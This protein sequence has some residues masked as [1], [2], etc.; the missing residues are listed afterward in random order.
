M[1]KITKTFTI[2][3]GHR[4]YK[5]TGKCGHIHGHTGSVEMV[6]QGAYVDE[7]GMLKNFDSIKATVGKWLDDNLD[8]HMLLSKDDP[9]V[10][11]LTDAGEKL[12]ILN[13]NPTAENLA[14]TIYGVAKEQG[15]PVFE[16]KFWESPTSS[17]TYSE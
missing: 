9:L 2:C 3:Y 5:D 17:A 1:Y 16:V 15:L 14:R 13:D 8:H 4:L 12:Y 11:P 7:L 6:L 10:K